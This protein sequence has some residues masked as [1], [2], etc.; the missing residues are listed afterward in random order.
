[1]LV[2]S[3]INIVV[4]TCVHLGALAAESAAGLMLIASGAS[5]V[6]EDSNGA[7]IMHYAARYSPLSSRLSPIFS[8]PAPACSTVAI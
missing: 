1:M 7:T 5:I 8:A 2:C 4:R 6:D 3:V